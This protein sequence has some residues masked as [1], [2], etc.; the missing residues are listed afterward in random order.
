MTKKATKKQHEEKNNSNVAFRGKPQDRILDYL[1][2]H[3]EEEFNPTKVSKALD[4]PY[5]KTTSI[6]SRLNKKGKIWKTH[7][8]FYSK[9]CTLNKHQLRKKEKMIPLGV[10]NISMPIPKKL[11][12]V[13]FKL[14][15]NLLLLLPTGGSKATTKNLHEF[16]ENPKSNQKAT[17]GEIQKI[18]FEICPNQTV[19]IIEYPD[20]FIFELKADLNPLQ[21]SEWFWLKTCMILLFGEAV[22]KTEVGKID[23]NCD[24]PFSVSKNE[25]TIGDVNGAVLSIYGKNDVTRA[26]GR[27]H[28]PTINSVNLLMM[29]MQAANAMN[30]ILNQATQKPASEDEKATKK[31]QKRVKSNQKTTSLLLNQIINP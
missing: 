8:G 28:Q 13:N 17:N 6:L 4:I 18:S 23:F 5:N 10:H 30:S 19:T 14:C 27:N 21:A 16:D 11:L 2:S 25:I 1:S 3:P 26:E 7:H 12:N 20:T 15:K 9:K 24:L 31:Q 29:L 22:L